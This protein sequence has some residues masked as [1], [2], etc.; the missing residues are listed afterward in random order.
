MIVKASDGNRY[1]I[2]QNNLGL[3]YYNGDYGINK[4]YKKAFQLIENSAN[5]NYPDAQFTMSVMYYQ[6]KAVPKDLKRSYFW[7]YIAYKNGYQKAAESV[8][9]LRKSLTAEDIKQEEKKA[10][11]W[12]KEHPRKSYDTEVAILPQNATK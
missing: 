3:I 12:L 6:G 8:Q 1:P 9:L 11:I 5:Q 7:S 10:D 4:N 2:A